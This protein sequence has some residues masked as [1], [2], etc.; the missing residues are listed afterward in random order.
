MKNL[1]Q[2]EL[3][4]ETLREVFLLLSH[5]TGRR[6]VVF[7]IAIPVCGNQMSGFADEMLR[8][9]KREEKVMKESGGRR[10]EKTEIK[11]YEG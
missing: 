8:W 1:L 7:E 3:S 10:I 6:L 11:E 4:L 2:T 9:E 5:E